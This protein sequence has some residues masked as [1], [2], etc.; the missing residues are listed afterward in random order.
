MT[1]LMIGIIVVIIGFLIGII[2]VIKK[3]KKMK[4]METEKIK[5]MKVMKT[6]KIKKMK[7]MKETKG[8]SEIENITR[9]LVEIEEIHIDNEDISTAYLLKVA[10]MDIRLYFNFVEVSRVAIFMTGIVR[11]VIR[12]GYAKIDVKEL[13]T[14]NETYYLLQLENR[15]VKIYTSLKEATYV[16]EYMNKVMN[17]ILERRY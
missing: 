3:F 14:D 17:N 13:K 9:S 5:K 16:A 7:V 6:E 2:L 1:T 8:F 15:N 12:N 11:N 4:E 10:G